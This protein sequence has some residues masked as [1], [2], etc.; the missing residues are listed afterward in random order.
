M[1]ASSADLRDILSLPGP[2]ATPVAPAPKKTTRAH[3]PEGI[4]RELYSLIGNHAPS[5]ALVQRPKPKFKQKPDFG[6]GKVHWEWRTFTNWARKDDLQLGH[7]EKVTEDRPTDEEWT[8]EETDY[9]FNLVREYDMRWFVIIDRYEYPGGPDRAL[10]RLSSHKDLKARYYSVC[11]KLIRNRPWL[12]DEAAKSALLNSYQF[13]KGMAP[14]LVFVFV[15]PST[16]REKTRKMYVASLFARTPEQI[17]EEEAL[18]VEIKRLEQRERRFAKDREELM[19]TVAGIESGLN[20]HQPD[21]E[22]FSGLF[23][24]P[25]R[26]KKGP[27]GTDTDSTA[28]TSTGPAKKSTS[29]KQAQHDQLNCITRTDVS[30]TT[31]PSTKT[32]HTPAHLRSSKLPYPKTSIAPRVTAALAE[33]RVNITRLVMPTKENVQRLETLIE[34]TTTMIDMKKAVDRLDHEIRTHKKL[35]GLI[36]SEDGADPGQGEGSAEPGDTRDGDVNEDTGDFD[37]EMSTA[38]MDGVMEALPQQV[39]DYTPKPI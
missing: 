36:T 5:L 4:S 7:W 26:K 30:S 31:A 19:K 34:A 25:K 15:E 9:L 12:G 23:I 39:R 10:E 35:L 33:M 3:K 38:P 17:A 11:R 8:K 6:R 16:E 32:A 22:A 37:R 2:S 24:D 18:Y 13:D 28:G 14:H 1:A 21:E 20:V 27:G 29:T